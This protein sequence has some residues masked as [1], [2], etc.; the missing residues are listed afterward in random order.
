ML[1]MNIENKNLD[2]MLKN[3][4]PLISEILDNALSE[5]EIDIKD[6]VMLFSARGTDLEVV[7]SVADELRKRR[8]GDIV[9]YVVNR[10]INFTNVCVKQCGFC[11][12]SR[13]FREE[14]GYFLPTHEIVRRA[15]EAHQLGATEVCIQAGLPPDMDGELYEKICREIKK[16][17]PNMHIHGFSPEEILYAA[18]RNNITIRDY[19]LRLKNAGVDTIPGTSAEILDQDLRNKISPGRISVKEWIKVIKTAHK[20]G[21]GS[22]STMMYGHM[23]SYVDRANHIGIIRKIQ[24]ETGGFTEF[25]PLNFVHTEAPMYKHGLHEGIQAG[26]D[27]DDIMLTHAVSRIM[28]NN[29]IDNIQMS[30]VKTGEKMSQKLLKCGANDFGGTLINESISTAAGSQHGQLLKPK[31][32]R[33]LVRDIGRIPAERNTTYKILRTFENE[34]KDDEFDHIDDTSKFGSYFDLIKINKFRYKNPRESL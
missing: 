29:C 4:D 1:E 18:T 7:C 2:V 25:V 5:K 11:A 8:V 21:L 10:N 27:S 33:R 12:F 19:L 17:I 6:A 24:K 30:W 28:L 31:Q 26:A 22:T 14:E 34:P 13:D 20:I 3:A 32:I 9:T 16:E 15:K 23:E